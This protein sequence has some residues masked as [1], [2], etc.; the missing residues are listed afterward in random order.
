LKKETIHLR[1]GSLIAFWAG[2]ASE[3]EPDEALRWLNAHNDILQHFHFSSVALP[4][5]AKYRPNASIDLIRKIQSQDQQASLLSLLTRS[6]VYS[7]SDIY[8]TKETSEIL[9]PDLVESVLDSFAFN[10]ADRQK[11]VEAI[12]GRREYEANKPAPLPSVW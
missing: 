1:I 12:R 11:V 8:R 3:N 7:G 10:E 4:Y 9:S 2:L 6:P 5:L